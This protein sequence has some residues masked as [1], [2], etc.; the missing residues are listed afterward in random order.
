M[1]KIEPQET[2]LASNQTEIQRTPQGEL[3]FEAPKIE[4]SEQQN[5]SVKVASATEPRWRSVPLPSQSTNNATDG[6]SKVSPAS[7]EAKENGTENKIRQTNGFTP[8]TIRSKDGFDAKGVLV[9]SASPGDGAPRYALLNPSGAEF[10][11]LAYLQSSRG[12]ILESFIGKRVGVKGEV[13][14]VS[15]G[16]KAYKLVVVKSVFPL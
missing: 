2:A 10:S 9:A 15:V 5:E 7:S 6:S 12:V 4:T 1:G 13:G 11:V 8:V 14:T 16:G 3:V